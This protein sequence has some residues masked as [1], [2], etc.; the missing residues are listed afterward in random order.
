MHSTLLQPSFPSPN[1]ST[2]AHP[3]RNRAAGGTHRGP[4]VPTTA[5]DPPLVCSS[6]DTPY[7]TSTATAGNKKFSNDPNATNSLDGDDNTMSSNQFESLKREA[8]KLER[9]LEEKV[10]KYQQ[11]RSGV[12]HGVISIS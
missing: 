6:S 11:V 3:L 2:I 9:Q 12:S 1:I 10:A 5:E 4:S 7:L 8:T